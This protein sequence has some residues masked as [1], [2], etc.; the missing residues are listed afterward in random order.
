MLPAALLGG[1]ERLFYEDF[2]FFYLQYVSFQNIS[3]RMF[4]RLQ[5]LPP[6]ELLPHKFVLSKEE[7]GQTE[8]FVAHWLDLGY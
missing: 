1:L 2:N 4:I 8:D 3:L 5:V 7:L 6:S